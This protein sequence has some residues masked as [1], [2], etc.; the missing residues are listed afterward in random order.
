MQKQE[1]E[2]FCIKKVLL[3]ILQYQQDNTCVVVSF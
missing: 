1:P 3:K 2:V